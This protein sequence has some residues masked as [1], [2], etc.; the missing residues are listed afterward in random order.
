M[1]TQ[2]CEFEE[3]INPLFKMKL[4]C[5]PTRFVRPITPLDHQIIHKYL[6]LCLKCP[7]FGVRGCVEDPTLTRDMVKI[8][9]INRWKPSLTSQF[10][11]IWV[12]VEVHFLSWYQSLSLSTIY[13]Y[14]VS[15]L[16]CP[17]LDVRGCV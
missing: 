14:L 12:R 3:S 5:V 15:C 10:C 1:K 2:F 7:I 16:K 9:Y 11:K 4:E 13:K 8:Y 17:I 6:V